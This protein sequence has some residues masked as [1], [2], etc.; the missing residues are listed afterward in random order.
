MRHFNIS[1]PCDPAMH[2]MVPPEARTP[3]L[4]GYLARNAYFVVHAPRQSG[5]TTAL[6]AFA[7]RLTREGRYTA[8]HLSCEAARA[9]ADVATAEERVWLAI[10]EAAEQRLPPE[11]RP[12]HRRRRRR[13]E[14]S[15]FSSAA[16]PSSAR[17]RWPWSSTRSTR[18]KGLRSRACS[19]S[20]ATATPT[21]PATSQPWSSSA[22]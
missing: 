1:G 15:P 21:V 12:P 22:G 7:E 9:F 20:S 2:Y 13:G 10:E 18:W 14:L 3:D 5:K 8:L 16:G 19:A 6:R 17:A 11:L 4:S